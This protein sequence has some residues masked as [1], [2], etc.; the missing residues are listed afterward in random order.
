[1]CL[2]MDLGP[3]GCLGGKTDRGRETGAEGDWRG[4]ERGKTLTLYSVG[5]APHPQSRIPQGRPTK[6]SP[7]WST[8]VLRP[9]TTAEAGELCGEES[10]R[11][12]PQAQDRCGVTSSICT[13]K[14]H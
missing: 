1:M 14:A 7:V 4:Q 11:C 8:H 5:G 10:P 12:C 2:P 6:E 9:R 3:D 13:A